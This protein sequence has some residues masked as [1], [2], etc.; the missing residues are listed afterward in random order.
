MRSALARSYIKAF[1]IYHTLQPYL[2]VA[3]ALHGINRLGL[4]TNPTLLDPPDAKDIIEDFLIKQAN[5]RTTTHNEVHHPMGI[6]GQRCRPPCN[7]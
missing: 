6:P 7:Y 3:Q 2:F 5:L 1:S 4:Q